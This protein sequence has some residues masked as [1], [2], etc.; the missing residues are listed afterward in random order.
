MRVNTTF[1]ILL[2]SVILAFPCKSAEQVP[3]GIDEGRPT[4]SMPEQSARTMIANA[5]QNEGNDSVSDIP[6]EKTSEAG[7]V[8]DEGCMNLMSGP[9]Y[10]DGPKTISSKC[11]YPVNGYMCVRTRGYVCI[12]YIVAKLEPGRRYFV[13]RFRTLDT[14]TSMKGVFDDVCKFPRVPGN[15]G[16]GAGALCYSRSPTD[17]TVFRLAPT[18]S[19]VSIRKESVQ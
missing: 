11:A 14:R 8:P 2:S 17:V 5:S 15:V 3:W 18:P 13:G 7:V 19:E 6:G 1:I 16:P 4:V 12:K 10:P 9:L